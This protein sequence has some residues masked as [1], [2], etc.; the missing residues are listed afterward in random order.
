MTGPSKYEIR[1]ARSHEQGRWIIH[2][3]GRPKDLRRDGFLTKWGARRWAQRWSRQNAEAEVSYPVWV[4]DDPGVSVKTH[5]YKV[6]NVTE[7]W[8]LEDIA[9]TWAN[10]GWRVVAVLSDTRTPIHSHALVL[11]RP[12][13]F[14]HL[15]D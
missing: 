8:T 11:E 13:G 14:L 10:Q 7:G 1:R 15:D 3:A 4:Q 12:T 2:T 9:N 5:D 6:V